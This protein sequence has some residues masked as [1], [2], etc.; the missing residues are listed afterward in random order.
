[1]SSPSSSSEPLPHPSIPTGLSKNQ[2]KRIIREQRRQELKHQHQRRQELSQLSTEELD[3]IRAQTATKRLERRIANDQRKAK[4][5]Y[6]LVNPNSLTIVLDCGYS[7]I[8]SD[9]ELQ[10]T[11]KQMEF[12]YGN[13]AK[14][15][16]PAYLS[17]ASCTGPFLLAMDQYHPTHRNW[18]VNKTEDPFHS[19][20][21][22]RSKE[23]IYLSAD[24]EEVLDAVDSDHAYIVGAVVDRNRLKGESLKEAQ[25]F[26]SKRLPL[27][28]H[29]VLKSSCVLTTVAVV[30]M[31][32]KRFSGMSWPM[33]FRES[34]P[35][36]KVE[37]FLTEG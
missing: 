31:L 26:K 14:L 16:S 22:C 32:V 27:P 29:V 25:A 17:F 20:S 10:S 4:L 33:V 19:S 1:M 12:I 34:L 36:R 35:K 8:L 13:N 37:Q 9:K 28:E 21:A 5:N 30:D 23:I 15:D 18:I 7:S 11:C 3:I 6:A 24:A 2:Q